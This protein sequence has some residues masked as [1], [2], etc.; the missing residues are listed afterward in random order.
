MDLDK[1]TSDI[2]RELKSMSV[3]SLVQLDEVLGTV[4]PWLWTRDICLFAVQQDHGQTTSP[5]SMKLCGRRFVSFIHFLFLV[6]LF[7]IFEE[8]SE[9]TPAC[10]RD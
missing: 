8:L 4:G 9:T 2:F 5:I 7:N 6:R 3:C 1:N 10:L